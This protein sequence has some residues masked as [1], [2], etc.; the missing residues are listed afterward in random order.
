MRM[1][2]K[3]FFISCAG[4]AVGGGEPVR[5][6][7]IDVTVANGSNTQAEMICDT[8]M[9]AQAQFANCAIPPLDR[10]IHIEVVTTLDPNCVGVY[11]RQ[12]DKIEILA[13]AVMATR[14][15]KDGAFSFLPLDAYFKGVLVHELTH[16]AMDEVPCLF[17]PCVA[18]HEYLAYAMQVMSLAP[19]QKQMF[20]DHANLDR[21]IS[22]DEIS[23]IMLYIAPHLFVQKVWTHLSQRPD[24]CA[25]LELVVDGTVKL[26]RDIP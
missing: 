14:R 10:P 23:A 12:C 15:T 13:P 19:H 1:A 18:S 2:L 24:P 25:F 3:A 5:C 11:H 9:R 7:G 20:E 6:D 26:D 22:R 21:K 8:A 4:T 17:E 16:A